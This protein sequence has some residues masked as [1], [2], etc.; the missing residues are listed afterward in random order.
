MTRVHTSQS[1]PQRG[2]S[3]WS[4]ETYPCAGQIEKVGVTVR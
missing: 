4:P 3:G 1:R 2:Q